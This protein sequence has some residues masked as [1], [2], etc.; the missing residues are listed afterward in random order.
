MELV[1]MTSKPTWIR[2][3][4]Q[5]LRAVWENDVAADELIEAWQNDE[6]AMQKWC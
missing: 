6:N 5:V 1:V 4:D 3:Y 2:K